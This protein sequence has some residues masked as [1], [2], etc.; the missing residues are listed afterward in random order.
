MEPV[1]I[2][3][4]LALIQYFWFGYFVAQARIRHGINAPA[5]SGHPEFDRSLR[6]QQNTLE[7][8]LVFLPGLWI[9]G[10][11]VHALTA[12][13][14]GLLFIAGRFVYRKSYLADPSSRTLGFAIGALATAVLLI[15]GAIG[16]FV[17][18]IG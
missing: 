15:G 5:T 13:L 14:L 6:I 9:F 2:I 10:W 16:A 12:A 3:T 8:L 17:S 4:A 7:Q 1:A 11:Y 18:W